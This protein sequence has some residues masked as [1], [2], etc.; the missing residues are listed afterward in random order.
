MMTTTLLAHRLGREI[1]VAPGAIPVALA[2]LRA[3][4]Y[5]AA[6]SLAHAEHDVACPGEV[7]S[8][9]D[10]NAGTDLTSHCPGITSALVPAI[11]THAAKHF[12]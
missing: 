11:F 10:A 4:G 5:D 9:L 8:H 2:R 7:I 12:V 6:M 1:G 3:D